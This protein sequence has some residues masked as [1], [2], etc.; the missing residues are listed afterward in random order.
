[1]S[2]QVTW[3]RPLRAAERR[4]LPGEKLRGWADGTPAE[5]GAI[6][7]RGGDR[8]FLR[9]TLTLGDLLEAGRFAAVLPLVE[10]FDIEA[11]SDFS[12]K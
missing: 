9:V 6:E 7:R 8:P 12:A 11:F 1:M 2:L 5:R 4:V 3:L 10:R